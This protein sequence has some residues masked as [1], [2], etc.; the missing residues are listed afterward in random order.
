MAALKNVGAGAIAGI[1]AARAKGGRFTSLSD[2]ARRVDV[3]SLNRRALESL[4]K[5]G[6]FDALAPNRAALFDGIDSIIGVANR[7]AGEQAA[8]QNDRF[9]SASAD[10]DE[11]MLPR[12]DAWLP[13]DRLAHEF[14]AV[15]FYL[16][17][18]PLDEYAKTL[19][20][21]G[22]ESW[23]QFREKAITKGASAAKLAGTITHRQE[24]RSKQ[25]NKFA[26]IG[27]SDA[28]GQYE[29]VVFSD[30]LN[31]SR[32][33][34]E[35]GRAVIVRV[36]ADVEG[37][38][39]KLRLQSVEALDKAAASVAQGLQIFLRDAASIASIAKRLQPGGKSP[40]RLTLMLGGGREV[41][42]GLGSRFQV[43]PQIKGA[44]KSIDGVVE[45][46]DL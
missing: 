46:Q 3:K 34:L 20:R 11:I 31:A 39:I 24:R 4:V 13:M 19:N 44:I 29:A 35:P 1:V 17:G 41:E 42:I 15:G 12:R 25:G 26:F 16:S 38:E 28:T 43:T 27:F 33:A 36:E 10:V 7:T 2:F 18:H 37:E 30:M 22:V 40:A 45:V 32:D 6:A 14:E 23:A 5:A 9:G 21:L 8:G